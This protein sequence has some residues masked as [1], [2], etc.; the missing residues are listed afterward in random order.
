MPKVYWPKWRRLAAVMERRKQKW[1]IA[2]SYL[3]VSHYQSMLI[4]WVLISMFK[5]RR[6]NFQ[7]W[8]IRLN[9]RIQ[10]LRSN[11]VC[12]FLCFCIISNYLFSWLRFGLFKY[13]RLFKQTHATYIILR[14]KF[15]KRWKWRRKSL[16]L[17]Q[18][19]S[20]S[21]LFILYHRFIWGS[22]S[23]RRWHGDRH[24]WT[25][26]AG[27]RRLTWSHL[28]RGLL[29]CLWAFLLLVTISMPRW[30]FS[31]RCTIH[32]IF[33]SISWVFNIWI[34]LAS[35]FWWFHFISINCLISKVLLV[36]NHDFVFL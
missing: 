12:N 26:W 5:H 36:L 7:Q 10:E 32:I 29:L 16:Y 23:R 3:S 8:L 2:T 17:G 6:L 9:L 21:R 13:C 28:L 19:S 27:W 34:V 31:M 24:I 22:Y 18:L 25:S 4:L 15:T 1:G 30:C 33:S 14:W 11:K 20:I 35:S